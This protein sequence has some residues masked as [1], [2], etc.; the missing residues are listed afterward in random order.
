[1]LSERARYK[2]LPTVW[3]YSQDSLT[4]A[5]LQSQ[6]TDQWLQGAGDGREMT[7]KTQ[8]DLRGNGTDCDT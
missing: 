8:G 1:M 6:K 4:K 7:T 2:R 5:K 3:F